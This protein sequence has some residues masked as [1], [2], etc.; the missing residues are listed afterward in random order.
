M[1]EDVGGVANS[2]KFDLEEDVEG[3][4]VCGE[5]DTEVSRNRMMS[6][7]VLSEA[8]GGVGERTKLS[9]AITSVRMSV[10]L[11][12]PVLYFSKHNQAGSAEDV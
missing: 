3:L 7:R 8:L 4:D 6:S 1:G 9:M 5:R 12:L 2:L 10:V 11:A